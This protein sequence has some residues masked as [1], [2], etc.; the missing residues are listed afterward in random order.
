MRLD[1]KTAL[2]TGAGSGMGRAAASAF[3]AAGAAVAC[4]DLDGDAAEATAAVVTEAGGRAIGLATDVSDGAQVEAAVAAT[5]RELG[6]LDVLYNNAGYWRFALDGYVEGETDGPSPL[7]SEE[8]WQQTIDVNLK[9]TYLGC[10]YGIPALQR[11]GGGAILNVSSVAAMR[12]GSGV[13]DAYTAAKAGV[14]G[15]TRT[16]AVEYG[17]EGIRVNCIVPGPIETPLVERIPAERR[18]AFGAMVPLGR[19]GRP[20]EIASMALFLASDASSFCTG[21]TFVVDGGYLAS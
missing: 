16:L 17:G 4:A 8:I 15:L 14:L 1:E 9:G 6:G 10:R 18:E 12:V 11:R 21:Q 20:E 5:E 19:W 2:I 7:L 13:S 3:A